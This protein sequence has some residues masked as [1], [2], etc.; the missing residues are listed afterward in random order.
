MTAG[1]R[2]IRSLLVSGELVDLGHLQDYLHHGRSFLQLTAFVFEPTHWD[3]PAEGCVD[4]V[5]NEDRGHWPVL[6]YGEDTSSWG[7]QLK[8]MRRQHEQNVELLRTDTGFAVTSAP[9]GIVFYGPRE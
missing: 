2:L 1:V 8:M 9:E 5:T 7:R 6:T 3:P 4:P